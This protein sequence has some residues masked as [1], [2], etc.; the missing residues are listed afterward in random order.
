MKYHKQEFG[1][2][3]PE[4]LQQQQFVTICVMFCDWDPLRIL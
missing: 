3:E 2:A 4:N 1:Q